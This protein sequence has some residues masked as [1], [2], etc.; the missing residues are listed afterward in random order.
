M[1]AALGWALAVAALG[2]GYAGYGWPGVALALT[3]VVF[4]LLLQFS[5]ALRVMRAAGQAPMGHISGGRS[6]LMLQSKIQRGMRLP[7]VMKLTGSFGVK[8]PL[9]ASSPPETELFVWTD[10]GGDAV[11]VVLTA[12]KVATWELRRAGPTLATPPGA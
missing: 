12:G 3:V 10:A 6:A 1:S 7:Q 8:A 11:Q 2:L 4:W 5:R 9:L